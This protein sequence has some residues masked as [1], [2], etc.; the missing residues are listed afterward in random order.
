M[1]LT[2][3]LDYIKQSVYGP[4]FYKELPAKPFSFS[5]KY[6]YKLVLVLS[7]VLAAHSSFKIIPDINSFLKTV[8]SEILNNYPKE[9]VLNIKNG[10]ASSNVAEPYF[11]RLPEDLRKIESKGSFRPENFIVIDTK[12]KF[13]EETFKKYNTLFL[14]TKT[15]MAYIK[16]NGV[17]SI[18]PLNIFSDRTIDY[19][20]A[21]SIAEKLSFLTKFIWVLGPILIFIGFIVQF[22]AYLFYLLFGALIIWLIYKVGK[23]PVGY[24][25]S[26]QTG[27]HIITFQI[28]F[29]VASI[30]FD[31]SIQIP[32]FALIVFIIIAVINLFKA[33]QVESGT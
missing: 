26:Y 4:E 8:N 5:F 18:Q 19:A 25:K 22:S 20:F 1:N 30:V 21:A 28:L 24:K 17:I 15:N 23:I 31:F 27:L 16:D 14:F 11:V 3:F 13:T 6:F 10:E 33:L 2:L 7:I 12:N 32:F 29:S 9:L